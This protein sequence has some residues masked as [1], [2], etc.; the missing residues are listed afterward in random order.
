M[1]R[2][3]TD[4]YRAHIYIN[5]FVKEPVISSYMQFTVHVKAIEPSTMWGLQNYIVYI[6]IKQLQMQRY[7]DAF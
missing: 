3:T 2:T 1:S 7:V 4:R 5:I 6:Q